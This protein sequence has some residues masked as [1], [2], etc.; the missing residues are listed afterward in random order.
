M[1]FLLCSSDLSGHASFTLC[2]NKLETKADEGKVME[3]K[4]ALD[5]AEGTSHSTNSD[6]DTPVFAKIF[7][8]SSAL[9]LILFFEPHLVGGEGGFGTSAHLKYE[10]TEGQS[11]S[12]ELT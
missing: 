9:L 11:S 10:K 4:A 5:Q 6:V 2:C 7:N 1:G 3:S 12:S 8:L